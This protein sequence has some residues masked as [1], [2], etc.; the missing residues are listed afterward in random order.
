M[1]RSL[2]VLLAGAGVAAA[3]APPPSADSLPAGARLRI[4]TAR[5]RHGGLV[6]GLAFSPDGKSVASASHDH[7]V[8]VWSVPAGRERFRFRGHTADVL[9]VAFSRA[10]LLASGGADGTVALWD[11]RTG[12]LLHRFTTRAESIETVEFDPSGKYLAAGGDD[13]V[14]LLY[15]AATRRLVRR[16]SQDRAVRSLAWSGDGRW[17][18][19]TGARQAIHLYEAATG[20]LRRRFGD[21][22]VQCLA[23]APGGSRLVSREEGGT[24]RL[25]DTAAGKQVRQWT[26]AEER[27][28][29]A[30]SSIYQI[31]FRPGGKSV[32]GGTPGGVLEEWDVDT[33]KRLA[34]WPAHQGRLTAVAVH[35]A[36]AATGGADH[37]VILHDLAARRPLTPTVEPAAGVVGLSAAGGGDLLVLLA[38]GDVQLWDRTTGRRRKMPSPGPARAALLRPDGREMVLIDRRGQLVFHNVKTGMQKVID[39]TGTLS[40]LSLSSDGTELVTVRKDGAVWLRGADGRRLRDVRVLRRGAHPVAPGGGAGALLGPS[41]GVALFETTTGRLRRPVDGHRGG[42][43]AAALSPDGRLL[44]SGGRDRM[45]RLWDVQTAL[46]RRPPRE[47]G[48]WVCAVAF[49]PDGRVLASATTAG[50]IQ[51]WEA[52]SGKL[53]GERQGHRGPVTSLLFPDRTTLVSAGQDTSVLVWDVAKV[54]AERLVAVVLTAQERDALWARLR[55]EDPARAHAALRRL[56]RDAKAAVAVV[57]GGVRPVDGKRIGRW[58][59]EL[60]SD[61]FLVRRKAFEEL[62]LVG[63]LAEAPLRQA[64][65]KKPSL[66]KH[67]R[68]Q[69]LLR[70][71]D[72]EGATPEHLQALRGVELL[73]RVGSAGARKVLATLAGGAPE[74]ELTRQAKAALGRL[75]KK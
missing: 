40:D 72:A 21:E 11:T 17:I 18:A 8:S 41:A 48:D 22:A 54:E 74:A 3:A 68:I 13:G 73:E 67:R 33:G 53:L 15:E 26:S 63:R 36:V 25:W 23:F 69:E 35:A 24:F 39:A 58:I 46:P 9:C 1:I 32:L 70:R 60:D 28:G 47:H 29:G 4:G 14:L 62:T 37:R 66:E 34:R 61:E 19:A 2:C 75:G 20:K 44:A 65:A 55:E 57:R 50:L 30:A 71:M 16:M 27:G 6:R 38:T 64:L 45:L 51:M 49:S 42:T 10:G 59:E 56:A 52:G 31:A 7:T 5:L 12:K 43:M